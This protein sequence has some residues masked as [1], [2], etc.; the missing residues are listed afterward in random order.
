VDLTD[1]CP[2][3]NGKIDRT[4]KTLSKKSNRLFLTN[5]IRQMVK[6]ILTGDPTLQDDDF[7]RKAVDLLN[8][9]G[10]PK[11]EAKKN[12]ITEFVN[13]STNNIPVLS[14]IVPLPLGRELDLIT[15]CRAE[16]YICLTATGLLIM[17]KIA[18][19]LFTK[20]KLYPNWQDYAKK[21]GC[22]IN[23]ERSA[24]I[25]QDTIISGGKS[26]SNKGPLNKAVQAVKAAIGMATDNLSGDMSEVKSPFLPRATE[27]SH[28]QS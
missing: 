18:Y 28:A 11:Y 7:V 9:R 17:A 25:W 15:E 3:F 23:W 22:E 13:I 6:T 26:F 20:R 16:G 19:E 21:L 24:P 4:S 12:R 2:L 8:E 5:H 14:Q 1:D 10:D 27:A